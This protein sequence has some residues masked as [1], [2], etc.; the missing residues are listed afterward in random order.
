MGDR[1]NFGVLAPEQ[2]VV[3][4]GCWL[5][6]W[7]LY[8]PSGALRASL[9]PDRATT[10]DVNMLLSTWADR[11]D[12]FSGPDWLAGFEEENVGGWRNAPP[13]SKFPF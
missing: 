13:N 3:N 9:R 10:F 4:G 1:N 7:R 2:V 11:E 12:I 6:A 5:K 8:I